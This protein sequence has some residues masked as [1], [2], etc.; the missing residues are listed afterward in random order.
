MN[1]GLT[2]K[3]GVLV[4]QLALLLVTSLPMTQVQ[5]QSKNFEELKTEVAVKVTDESVESVRL[6]LLNQATSIIE[7][8]QQ[9]AERLQQEIDEFVKGLDDDTKEWVN[10]GFKQVGDIG[11][12][13]YLN[14][15]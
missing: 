4:S 3:K 14:Q 2:I 1:K 6:G 10:K 15:V 13:D 12:Q 9:K 8:K 11:H 7:S 5:A